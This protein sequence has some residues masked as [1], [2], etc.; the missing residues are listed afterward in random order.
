MGGA[1]LQKLGLANYLK[2]G[3]IQGWVK[4]PEKTFMCESQESEKCEIQIILVYKY[5]Y[6]EAGKNLSSNIYSS[7][8]I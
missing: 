8:S 4:V 5:K 7:Q 3:K 1:G 6:L 2:P